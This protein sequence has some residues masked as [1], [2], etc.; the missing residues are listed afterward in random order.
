[1]YLALCVGGME[2]GVRANIS[3]HGC[4]ITTIDT[5]I[6]IYNIRSFNV[7]ILNVVKKATYSGGTGEKSSLPIAAGTCKAKQS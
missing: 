4:N 1:M 7:M 5:Y 3:S 2:E 6:Y